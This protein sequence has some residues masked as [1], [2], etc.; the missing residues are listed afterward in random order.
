MATAVVT[1]ASSGI[2]LELAKL[3]AADQHDLVLVAR[4][5]AELRA[6]ADALSRAH[7]IRTHVVAADLADPAG[8]DRVAQAVSGARL[9]VDILI[10]NAGFGTN[11]SFAKQPLKRQLEMIQVNITALTALTHAFLPGMIDR[12]S[13]RIMHVASTAAF[14]PG[15]RM[16]VYYATKAYVLS[17]SV[18]LSVELEGSGVTVTAVCPGPTTTGF[19]EVAGMKE[20]R[21]IQMGTM[22]AESVAGAGYRGM[23]AGRPIVIPGFRNAV[24]AFATRAVPIT[25]AARA[26]GWTHLKRGAV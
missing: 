17:V 24:G 19:Q 10:N 3:L 26:A 15:P 9:E 1:G 6:L 2:G 14:Q 16:A 4:R 20:S 21:L 13:G 22:T 18:A 5:E 8:S 11:G 25:W 7:K 12:Q 23:L